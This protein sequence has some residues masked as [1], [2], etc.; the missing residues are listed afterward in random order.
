[1]VSPIGPYRVYS[2]TVSCF[3]A[4]KEKEISDNV[5]KADRAT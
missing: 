1:M 2:L 3:L 4:W 5:D